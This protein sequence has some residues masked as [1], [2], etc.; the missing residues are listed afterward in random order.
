[1]AAKQRLTDAIVKRLKPPEKGYTVTLDSERGFGVRVT[2]RG[3][4]S[5]ILNYYV[6]NR[7]RCLT[8]GQHPG[9]GC[10]A[11]RAL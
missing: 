11:A 2:A 9:W 4:R 7:D 10:A 5:Y 1:M 6:S 3:V 8:I